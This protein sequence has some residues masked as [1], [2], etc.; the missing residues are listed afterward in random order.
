VAS[1]DSRLRNLTTAARLE[2]YTT[3]NSIALHLSPYT[4]PMESRSEQR[5]DVRIE[6]GMQRQLHARTQ[7]LAAGAAHR[8]WKVG[9]STPASQAAAGMTQ[10]VLGFLTDATELGDGAEVTIGGWTRPTVEA[11]LAILLASDVA[12]QADEPERRSA[13]GAVAVAIEVVDVT[14]PLDQLESLLAADIFH[15]H[16]LVGPWSPGRAGGDVDGVGIEAW[17][18]GALIATT[19]DPC[20][21]IGELPDVVGFVADELAAVGLRLTAG[22]TI[23]AGS[24]IPLTPVQPGQRLRVRGSTLGELTLSFTP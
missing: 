11:E 23:M 5:R 18:D 2:R 21:V 6:R 3:L 19:E 4:A 12:G 17:L 1:A 14:V 8:G 20:S 22:D 7:A 9:L 10:P 15:R 16:F 13:I 24:A